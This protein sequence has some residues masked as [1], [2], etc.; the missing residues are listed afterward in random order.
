MNAP[1]H[2]SPCPLGRFDE[3]A[4]AYAARGW[5]VFPLQ[6]GSK[7]P[8][9]GTHGVL[10]ATSDAAT[11]RG[12]WTKHPDANIGIA[13]GRA[14]G[15]VVTD[16]DVKGGHDPVGSLLALGGGRFPPETLRSAT[17][18]DGWHQYFLAP[19]VEIR[20]SAG[21]LGPGLDV[22]GEGGY[23]LAPP[24]IV[25][26]KAYRWINDPEDDPVAEM[27]QWL[28]DAMTGVVGLP[29]TETPGAIPSGQRN[30]ALA[31]LA[32]SMRNRGMTPEAIEAALLAE[33]YA[34]CDPPLA[35]RE[36]RQIAKSIGR[37]EPGAA[38]FHRTDLGNACRLVAR[39]GDDLRYVPDFKK[40]LT[41]D[42]A[43][44]LFDE[45]GEVMRCAK[46]TALSIY[47]EAAAERDNERR[48]A[49]AVW[50]A[51]SE[52]EQRLRAMLELAKSEPGVPVRPNE[53]DADPW[54]LSVSNGVV[55]L[56]TGALKEP[57]REDYITK[58]AQVDF[59]QGATCPAW[60]TFLDRIFN[61]DANL[62][63]FMQRAVGYSLT[64]LTSEQLFF[65]LYGTGQNGKSTLL[66]V[67]RALLGDYAATAPAA[68]FMERD[69]GGPTNDLARL[70]GA[71]FVAAIETEDGQ[72]L[73][74]SLVKQVTGEDMISSRFLYA[75][76][77]E[78]LP[79]FKLWLAVNHRPVIKGDD[80]AI[81]RRI[82][83]VPFEVC[84][85]EGEKDKTLPGKLKAE[86]PGILN[87]ALEGC[88]L[89]Q[90]S[91][92]A[93]PEA[94]M[95][96]TEAYRGEM[97]VLQQFFDECCYIDSGATVK[98]TALYSAYRDWAETNTGWVLSQTKFG[99]KLGDRRFR[100][101]RR[102]DQWTY[103][104]IGLL[105]TSF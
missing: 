63:A 100:K 105:E 82:R 61:G 93:A 36:V 11:I 19:A 46:Q 5:R 68:T 62:I 72:K 59:R 73:A 16:G 33:N 51:K 101:E 99:R 44:W 81:W 84:I 9:K 32:G 76:F 13:T 104:G 83:L 70:R 97:D 7:K 92:L 4:L 52:G 14:S 6:P 60:L 1:I 48:K 87:W 24:S 17:P 53:L 103:F 3:A 26:G 89:W 88:R 67:L 75:E 50:A 37:Y 28:L 18:S 39:H 95:A 71:R 54:L 98:A 22:R 80:Y 34:R 57:R 2:G 47:G 38:G 55:D 30:S 96:A 31:S 15:I 91:G 23:V 21:T 86:L 90:E 29:R 94:V 35:E 41:W 77:F 66:G 12:W 27:P 64:G 45:D 69:K 56:R 102:S 78:Y 43:R 25:N 10:D 20:N 8:F 42:G 49:L 58:R 65:L 74:E 79:A 85:P 40:W